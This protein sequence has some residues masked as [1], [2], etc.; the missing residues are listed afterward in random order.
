MLFIDFY[1]TYK[2]TIRFL[3]L[4]RS[5]NI[6]NIYNI[7]KIKK[8]IFYFTFKKLEDKDEIQILNSFYLLKFFLGQ[9]VFFT[10]NKS[11]FLLGK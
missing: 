3:L 6:L 9:N 4:N 8:L 5:G 2:N 1:F 10:K 7:P 11:F